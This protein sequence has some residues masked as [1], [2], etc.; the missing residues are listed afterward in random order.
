MIRRAAILF[1]IL[2]VVAAVAPARVS[3][4]QAA[5]ED[6]KRLVIA[7]L[8]RSDSL[9]RAEG[10][11]VVFK[12]VPFDS[13][14]IFTDTIPSVIGGISYLVAGYVPPKTAD[15]VYRAAAAFSSDTALIPRKPADLM[16]LARRLGWWPEGLSASVAFCGE[17]IHYTGHEYL[18]RNPPLVFERWSQLSGKDPWESLDSARINTLRRAGVSAP[19]L[20]HRDATSLSVRLWAIEGDFKTRRYLCT[21]HR[22]G[23]ASLGVTDSVNVGFLTLVP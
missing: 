4:A 19:Q 8:R 23:R 10:S 5:S 9:L 6:A 12:R 22:D 18:S 17:L 7:E 3:R 1:R 14:I 16:S 13:S 11:F 21:L 15:I 2:A 20:T